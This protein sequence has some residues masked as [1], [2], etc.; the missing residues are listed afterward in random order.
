MAVRVPP[1]PVRALIVTPVTFIGALAVTILSPLI[2]LVLAGIDLI[3]RKNW[4]FTR[5]VGLGVAF[6]VVE[7]FGLVMAFLLWVASGFGLWMRSAPIQRLH[8]WVFGMWLEM[9]TSAIR[10]FLG[11]EF[12]FSHQQ[13]PDGPSLVFSRHAGP[14]DALL[15]AHSL[16]RDHERKVRM[17]GTTKLLWDPFF[18]HVVRRLPF[19]FCEQDPSDPERELADLKRS[20]A[21]IE[22]DGA[23]IIFPEG[24]NYTPKRWLEA[25]ERL[26]RRGQTDRADRAR[27]MTHVLPPRTAGAVAALEAAPQANVVFV[28]HVGLDDLFSLGDLWRRVPIRRTVQATY[29]IVD[30]P[31][32]DSEP[33]TTAEWLWAQW[34]LVDRWIDEHS[35]TAFETG[36]AE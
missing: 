35:P 30:R 16:I 15:V 10:T 8:L 28:A 21:T 5:I 34:E 12:V 20:A 6:C 32:P 23:M 24:G 31:V 11:F 26:A 29:W 25:Q 2:H 27:R 36:L 1:A 33:R 3:D 17:L 13:L 22:G 7:T 4:R 18:N 9:I 19:H 14:G